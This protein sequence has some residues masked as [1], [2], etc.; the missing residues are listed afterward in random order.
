MCVCV[1]TYITCTR[2]CIITSEGASRVHVT[3]FEN[4]PTFQPI[5][6]ASICKRC[7]GVRRYALVIP[8]CSHRLR[9]RIES[10]LITKYLHNYRINL[11]KNKTKKN[12]RKRISKEK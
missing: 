8:L 7:I 10:L 1:F 4:L 5:V 3:G 2:L 9:T 12:E 11:K 6:I